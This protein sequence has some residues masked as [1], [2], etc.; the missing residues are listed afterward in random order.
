MPVWFLEPK[1]NESPTE[2]NVYML[3]LASRQLQSPAATAGQGSSSKSL[4]ISGTKGYTEP[5]QKQ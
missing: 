5:V 1:Q 3:T 4:S 2:Y